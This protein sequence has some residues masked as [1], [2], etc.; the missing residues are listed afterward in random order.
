ML[1]QGKSSGSA[2]LTSPA[3]SFTKNQVCFRLTYTI[4]LYAVLKLFIKS[5][6]QA[7][8]VA[9]IK[10][11][12]VL[13]QNTGHFTDLDVL[14]DVTSNFQVCFFHVEML[15]CSVQSVAH[16]LTCIGGIGCI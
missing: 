6:R 3:Y 8:K 1:E 5:Y 12:K 9:L 15:F 7:D 16:T 14:I 11:V 2:S 10:E 13:S 4:I